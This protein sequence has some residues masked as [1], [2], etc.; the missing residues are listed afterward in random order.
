[1]RSRTGILPRSRCRWTMRSPPPGMDQACRYR[2]VFSRH[3]KA[4]AVER[5]FSDAGSI[6]L[7]NVAMSGAPKLAA[8]LWAALHQ[9][10]DGAG[11][12]DLVAL[13]EHFEAERQDAAIGLGGRPRLERCHA[14]SDRVAEL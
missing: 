14:G 4:A 9:Q 3:C 5:K 10:H 7:V 6:A 8:R 13:V 12:D 2:R 11:L 1:M